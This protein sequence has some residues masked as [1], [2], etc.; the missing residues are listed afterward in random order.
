MTTKTNSVPVESEQPV[1]VRVGV[2]GLHDTS[3]TSLLLRQIGVK[4]AMQ[5]RVIISE[6]KKDFAVEIFLVRK[7]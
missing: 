4:L 7:C 3:D 6:I 2:Y 5:M 1:T